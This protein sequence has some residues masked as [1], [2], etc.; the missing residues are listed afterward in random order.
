[1]GSTTIT[2]LPSRISV[3]VPATRPSSPSRPTYPSCSTNTDADPPGAIFTSATEP[4]LPTHDQADQLGTP[5]DIRIPQSM[6][7]A[8]YPT[9]SVERHNH[10]IEPTYHMRTTTII[11]T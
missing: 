10:C 5:R 7:G 3:T 8:F 11:R 1:A 6:V 2:A 9:Y 4:T